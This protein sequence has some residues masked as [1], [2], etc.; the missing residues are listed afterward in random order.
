M[1]GPHSEEKA[2]EKAGQHSRARVTGEPR[3]ERLD[4]PR[5]GRA[6]RRGI[7]LHELAQ[8]VVDPSIHV[9]N[10]VAPIAAAVKSTANALGADVLL[11]VAVSAFMPFLRHQRIRQMLER[12]GYNKRV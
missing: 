6:P 12:G 5:I 3:G 10:G 2:G 11:V 4:G 8:A 1:S 7:P 9:F